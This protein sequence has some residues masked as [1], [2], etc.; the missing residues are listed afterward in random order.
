MDRE[1]VEGLLQNQRDLARASRST[2]VAGKAQLNL[3][4]TEFVGYERLQA[5]SRVVL[6]IAGGE[7]VEQCGRR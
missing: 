5:D 4:Q 3:P 2:A 1:Q 7:P 6:L